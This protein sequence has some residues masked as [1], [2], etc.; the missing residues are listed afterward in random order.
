MHTET[1]N[2]KPGRNGVG[3]N[4]AVFAESHNGAKEDADSADTI[5]VR[6]SWHQG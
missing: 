5:F 2:P 6:E 4:D 3:P 1:T